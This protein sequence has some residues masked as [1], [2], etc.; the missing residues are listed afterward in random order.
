[1]GKLTWDKIGK[2]SAENWSEQVYRVRTVHA[3]RGWALTTYEIEELDATAKVGK[4]DRNQ[5]L[6]ISNETAGILTDSSDDDDDDDGDGGD[7]GDGDDH[8]AVVAAAHANPVLPRPRVAVGVHRYEEGDT[9]MFAEGWD[10]EPAI[11]GGRR[12][13]EGIVADSYFAQVGWQANVPA[14]TVRFM[15]QKNGRQVSRD[16]EAKPLPRDQ[17]GDPEQAVDA[18]R[19]VTYIHS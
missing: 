16:Y 4:W 6:P 12:A 8:A 18:S 5:S 10:H 11:P 1:M 2:A 7:D 3:A 15:L 19:F 13:R 17:G 14:Y 9:L